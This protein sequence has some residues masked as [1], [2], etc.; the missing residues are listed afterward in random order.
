MITVVRKPL[1]F[2]ESLL[3]ATGIGIEKSVDQYFKERDRKRGVTSQLI[4]AVLSR[5]ISPGLLSTDLGRS[6]TEQMGIS[7]EPVIKRLQQ[8]G[9]EEFRPPAVTKRLRGGVIGAVPQPLPSEWV[10]KGVPYAEY[11]RK[12]EEA[13]EIQ[14]QAEQQKKASEY[15]WRKNVD[16]FYKRIDRLSPEEALKGVSEFMKRAERIPGLDL[17]TLTY[18]DP[19]LGISSSFLTDYQERKDREVKRIKGIEG[20][21]EALKLIETYSKA[22]TSANK[23]L[24]GI[25]TGESL[26]EMLTREI[27]LGEDADKSLKRIAQRVAK[28]KPEIQVKALLEFV[29]KDLH[30]KHVRMRR[31]AKEVGMPD[32]EVP[33]WEPMTMPRIFKPEEYLRRRQAARHPKLYSSLTEGLDLEKPKK[34]PK[35]VEAPSRSETGSVFISPALIKEETV[36]PS[37]V[38]ENEARW[39]YPNG[40]IAVVR[41]GK[42]VKVKK[43]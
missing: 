42:W 12:Q 8:E 27:F 38:L 30:S 32:Y 41:N 28:A 13:K 24:T 16:R 4:E 22:Q 34:E 20:G 33:D 6:F 23:M 40:D 18:T 39:Q 25:S 7:R 17:K 29:N 14:E 35:P 10:E 1:T 31:M 26:M 36:D 3:N 15:I 9:I 2:L 21:D 37:E 11:R 19:E 5:D 43:K